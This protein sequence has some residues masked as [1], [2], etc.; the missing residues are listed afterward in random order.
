MSAF[1]QS[2]GYLVA[3]AG[4]LMVGL[5]HTATGS[6]DI[7]VALLLV[8]A[9]AEL[10]VGVLAARPLVLPAATQARRDWAAWPPPREVRGD[11][12]PP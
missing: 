2:V 1:A 9:V 4:P 11:G 12:V 3:S 8:L 5:L 10:V 7:P 6:W